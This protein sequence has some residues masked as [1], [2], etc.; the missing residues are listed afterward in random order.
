MSDVYILKYILKVSDEFTASMEFDWLTKISS[1][2]QLL[3]SFSG[4]GF[5]S[6]HGLFPELFRLP[7]L[8]PL[9]LFYSRVE[10]LQEFETARFPAAGQ[11]LGRKFGDYRNDAGHTKPPPPQ[12]NSNSP[13]IN[14]MPF[15]IADDEPSESRFH[16]QLTCACASMISSSS[17]SIP[18]YSIFMVVV[19]LIICSSFDPEPC[20]KEA[21][22]RRLVECVKVVTEVTILYWLIR[23]ASAVARIACDARIS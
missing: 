10:A 3:I 23:D 6:V 7:S 21:C 11:N 5:F 9:L 15:N 18:K 8:A 4:C 17:F 14:D 22:T 16:T 1:T 20:T 19:V 2:R 13:T 12:I